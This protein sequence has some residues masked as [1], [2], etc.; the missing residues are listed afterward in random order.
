MP[1]K[2]TLNML[3]F[4]A[5]ISVGFPYAQGTRLI[6]HSQL[7]DSLEQGYRL[8]TINDSTSYLYKKP[9]AF[10]FIPNVFRNLY[11]VPLEATKKENLLPLAGVAL[12]TAILIY[13]DQD[14]IDASRRFGRYIGL[15]TDNNVY[16]ISKSKL[17]PF[18]VPVSL[19]ATLYYLGDGLTELSVNAGF[20]FYGGLKHDARAMRTASELTEGLSTVGILVQAMKRSTGRETPMR[21]SEP[22]GKWRFFPSIKEYQKSVPKYDAFP[23]GHLASAMATT[24]IIA[25]NYPEYKFIKPLCYSLMTLCGYQMMN[26]GV[27]WISDYPLALALGYSIGKIAVNRGRIKIADK[28]KITMETNYRL[29]K[30]TIQVY[31]VLFSSGSGG[32]A[33]C[34]RF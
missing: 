25:M 17:L 24:T 15:G 30:P 14:L 11:L 21:A 33:I 1:V 7:K 19:P 8:Y 12:S 6:E 4:L 20:Y 9:G 32:A 28:A 34:V 13:Y 29:Y 18:Y 26:N 5:F 10:E 3:L 22:R 2:C 23:S 31:P 27:H 16:N